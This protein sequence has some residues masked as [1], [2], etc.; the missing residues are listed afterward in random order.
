MSTKFKEPSSRI[1][2]KVMNVGCWAVQYCFYTLSIP[3]HYEYRLIQLFV[4]SFHSSSLI[5]FLSLTVLPR[6][7]L[8][9]SSHC[10]I[11]AFV[12]APR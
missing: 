5:A 8:S 7:T 12:T 1:Y 10:C 4:T 11:A 3:Q 6:E 2:L 9:V